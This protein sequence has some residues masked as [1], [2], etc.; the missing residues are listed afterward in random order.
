M[1]AK[2]L[3]ECGADAD[4]TGGRATE[5]TPLH[6]AATKCTAAAAELMKF[7]LVSGA[8]PDVSVR[9][10]RGL[11]PVSPNRSRRQYERRE[12]RT[13]S[14]E[15]GAQNISKWLNM[16]WDQLVEWAKEQRNKE[17]I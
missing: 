9:V 3:V 7:L 4:F 13:P 17:S 16:T 6:V 15:K 10:G 8:N 2:A 1:L 12:E 14:M 11:R 5:R